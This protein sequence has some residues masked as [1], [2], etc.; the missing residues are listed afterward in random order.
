MADP[1]PIRPKS[2]P[3]IRRLGAPIAVSAVLSIVLAAIGCA[4]LGPKVPPT[5]AQSPVSVQAPDPTRSV[6]FSWDP[7]D[8]AVE[9]G[10]IG[11][12][13]VATPLPAAD[14]SRA[15][16]E[17]TYR[18]LAPRDQPGTLTITRGDDDGRFQPGTRSITLTA[19]IGR[20]GNPDL[21]SAVLGAIADRL[22]SLVDQSSD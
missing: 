20:F 10:A 4:D 18:L 12:L 7:I 11:F 21:E 22:E 6:Y 5:D 17:R 2:R 8:G 9:E 3:T 19:R 16:F 15:P 1:H 13:V 14:P